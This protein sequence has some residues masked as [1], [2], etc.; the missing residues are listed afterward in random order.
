MIRALVLGDSHTSCIAEAAVAKLGGMEGIQIYRFRNKRSQPG[1]GTISM[2]DAKHLVSKMPPSAPLFLCVLGT[3]HNILGMLRQEPAFSFLPDGA[4]ILE[5][6]PGSEIIPMRALAS[7]FNAHIEESRELLEICQAAPGQVYL[8][9]S[10]PPKQNS[11]Y[12]LQKLTGMKKSTYR[13]RHVAEVGINPPAVRKA[14]WDLECARLRSWAERH[15]IVYVPAP[16]RAFDSAM[17]LKECYYA[18]DATHANEAY[19]S[20]VIDQ[21]LERIVHQPEKP[22]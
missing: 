20:L 11:E 8:L 7:A 4:G 19:G 6:A 21:I 5:E 12:M 16:P 1:D 2:D 9:G 3:Y 17:Y 22:A 13:G 10:P 15:H 14:F 18:E